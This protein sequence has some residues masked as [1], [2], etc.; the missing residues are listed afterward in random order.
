MRTFFIVLFVVLVQFSF[1]QE[2]DVDSVKHVESPKKSAYFNAT[3]SVTTK[4][5]STIPSLTLG[6]PAVFFEFAA[7][8]GKTSFEPRFRFGLDG[9]PWVFM[10]WLRHKPFQ[11]DRFSLT[12]G[13]HPAF[14]FKTSTLTIDDVTSET[15]TAQRYLVGDIIPRFKVARN[16]AIIPYYLYSYGVDE[17]MTKHS[18]FLQLQVDFFDVLISGQFFFRL[19][20]QIFYLTMDDTDGFYFG[21]SLSLGRRNFP[22]S[23]SAMFNKEI[24]SNI[25][26]SHDFLWNVTLVYSFDRN[27]SIKN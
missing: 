22:L 26:G 19:V 5:I 17:N 15:I 27:F 2:V 12:L 1:C 11:S 3:F 18:H 7:G 24:S 21:S 25:V 13:T 6:K 4:G 20:P 14:A 16:I 9:Q 23:V 8:I 10:L